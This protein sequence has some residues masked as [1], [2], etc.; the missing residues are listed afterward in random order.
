MTDE[1]E[2]TSTDESTEM[3]LKLQ[4]EGRLG[5]WITPGIILR[6]IVTMILLAIVVIYRN[7]M[8]NTLAN[9][10]LSLNGAIQS[11]TQAAVVANYLLLA[12]IGVTVF[13]EFISYLIDWFNRPKFDL[14]SI[15]HAHNGYL[16]VKRP[17]N[18]EERIGLSIITA[19]LRNTGRGM[20][21]RPVVVASHTNYKISNLTPVFTEASLLDKSITILPATVYQFASDYDDL[22]I[23]FIKMGMKTI[24][25]VQGHKEGKR[26][27]LGFAFDGG[28]SF[29]FASLDS[30]FLN[31][32]RLGDTK[33]RVSL[34][35]YAR[36]LRKKTLKTNI[37]A[38]FESWNNVKFD[39]RRIEGPPPE[40]RPRET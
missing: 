19:S 33:E 37:P 4:Q 29:Y 40:T 17:N 13:A 1:K 28:D 20:A 39:Y 25:S 6:T 12:L 32:I 11:P 30:A 34:G 23:Q 8:V 22:A 9:W 2:R 24:E 26:F 15:D 7:T 16:R 38:T 36:N 31:K 5:E 14:V 35:V 27:V 3:V 21:V 10:L 18:P